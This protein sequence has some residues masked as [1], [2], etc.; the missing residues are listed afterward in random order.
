MLR[1]SLVILIA[2]LLGLMSFNCTS[3]NSKD[4]AESKN[5]NE[6][7]VLVSYFSWSGNTEKVAKHIA[8]TIKGDIF[9]IEAVKKYPTDYKECTRVAREERR[10]K[11]RP[12]LTKKVS[13]F[14]QYDIIFIGYPIW[15]SDMPMPVYTFL[16]S[17]N[18]KGKTVIPFITHGGS[19]ESG[20]SDIIRDKLSGATVLKYLSIYDDYIDNANSDIDTWLKE[21]GIKK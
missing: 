1:K 14:E 21:I 5:N 2:C 20:T 4:K 13:K 3:N 9:K 10:N 18:F 11:V 12:D 8:E 6:K 7:K 15:W 19:D 17:Y 16:E